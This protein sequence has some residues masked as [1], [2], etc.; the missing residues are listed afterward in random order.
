MGTG[1]R[2]N[3]NKKPETRLTA[4]ITNGVSEC[5]ATIVGREIAAGHVIH[6][7][8]YAK[9]DEGRFLQENMVVGR[10]KKRR[11]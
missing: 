4:S 2:V 3:Q 10:C 11:R 8:N 9:C 1:S 6:E 5:S 7:S